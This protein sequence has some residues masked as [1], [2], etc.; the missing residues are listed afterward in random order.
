MRSSSIPAA[1]RSAW[2]RSPDS[3]PAASS[4]SS[5]RATASS[6]GER[7]G[8]IRFG[9]RLDIYVPLSTQVLVG[10]GQTAIAGETVLA[11]LDAKEPGRQFR[12]G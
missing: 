1:S 10:L 5:R 9:S 12:A 2:C 6:T 8:L 3:S 7:F 11:D 4:P